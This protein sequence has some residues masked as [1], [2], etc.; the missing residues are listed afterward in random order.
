MLLLEDVLGEKAE[1]IG[2]FDV[3]VTMRIHVPIWVSNSDSQMPVTSAG[4]T[5]HGKVVK[6]GNTM[7]GFMV[8]R[9]CRSEWK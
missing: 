8:S 6:I 4:Q 3:F 7:E 2:P 1:I 5:E 9:F